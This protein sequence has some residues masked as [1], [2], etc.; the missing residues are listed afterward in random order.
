MAHVTQRAHVRAHGSPWC[1]PR[2]VGPLAKQPAAGEIPLGAATT[3]VVS[4]ALVV[5]LEEEWHTLKMQ[6]PIYFI[7]EVLSNYKTHYP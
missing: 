6:R 3:Q 4:G 7:S 5:E 2:E 1:G